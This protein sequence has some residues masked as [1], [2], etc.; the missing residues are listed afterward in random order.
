V[1]D[2]ISQN[3]G[4]IFLRSSSFL[5]S[6][7]DLAALFTAEATTRPNCDYSFFYAG[8]MMHSFGKELH[9]E[10]TNVIDIG[11]GISH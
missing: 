9:F 10:K 3:M 4:E 6:S 5:R 8:A 2:S 1:I 7:C 11:L